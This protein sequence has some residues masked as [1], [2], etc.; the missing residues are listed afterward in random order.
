ILSIKRWKRD[1]PFVHPVAIF[2]NAIGLW[3]EVIIDP[4]PSDEVLKFGPEPGLFYRDDKLICLRIT[5]A[6]LHFEVAENC[7][8]YVTVAVGLQRVRDIPLGA[9]LRISL[10]PQESKVRIN[11]STA[12]DA[13]ALQWL[14]PAQTAGKRFPFLYTQSQPIHARSWIPIQDTPRIRL[15]YTARVRTPMGLCA[16]M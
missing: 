10:L 3:G 14:N 9:P 6:I 7:G 13:T 11:Y 12:S 16:V 2:L 8:S 1:W 15:T 4:H 5:Q